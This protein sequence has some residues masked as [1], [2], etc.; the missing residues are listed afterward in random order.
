MKDNL[1]ALCRGLFWLPGFNSEILMFIVLATGILVLVLHDWLICVWVL[2]TVSESSESETS[3]ISCLLGLVVLKLF[4][5]I[6]FL[7]YEATD[8]VWRWPVAPTRGS[9]WLSKRLWGMFISDWYLDFY[10]VGLVRAD[11]TACPSSTGAVNFLSVSLFCLIIPIVV[12]SLCSARFLK[13]SQI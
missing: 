8:G 4:N 11:C 13:P 10:I 9:P 1:L 7:D 6:E 5:A 12:L 2:I 3:R